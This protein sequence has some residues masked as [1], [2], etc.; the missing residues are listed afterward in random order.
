MAR[1]KG[2][3]NKPKRAAQWTC[4]EII[5]KWRQLDKLLPKLE[6]RDRAAMLMRM[7]ATAAEYTFEKPTAKTELSGS[8]NWTVQIA[9]RD[10][11]K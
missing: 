3:K 11:G 7:I 2:C 9:G 4:D 5:D 6:P 1:P 8:L 10:A